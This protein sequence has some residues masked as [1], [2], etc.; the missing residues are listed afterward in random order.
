MSKKYP[1]YDWSNEIRKVDVK[2]LYGYETCEHAVFNGKF[3]K[4]NWEIIKRD[5]DND[6]Q[7]ETRITIKVGNEDWYCSYW[8][9]SCGG[10]DTLQGCGEEAACDMICGELE[11]LEK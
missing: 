3:G 11:K 4:D 5:E 10:C 8:W 1:Q 9:G 6:Y 2:D 7:G